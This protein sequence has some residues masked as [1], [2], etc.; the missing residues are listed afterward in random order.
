VTF[1][2]SVLD[3]VGVEG[4]LLLLNDTTFTSCTD[5]GRMP[6][7]I[8]YREGACP[9]PFIRIWGVN[10]RKCLKIQVQIYAM[11]CR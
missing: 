6:T 2:A 5:D 9:F 3:T 4:D 8:G 7:R 10:P 1:I 11:W